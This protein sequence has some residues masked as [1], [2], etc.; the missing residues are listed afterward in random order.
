[1]APLE[2]TKRLFDTAHYKRISSRQKV[3]LI[4]TTK[5]ITGNVN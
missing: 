1:M 3:G 5:T 4:L 2:N